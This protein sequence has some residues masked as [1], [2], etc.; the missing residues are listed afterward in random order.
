MA[1]MRIGDVFYVTKEFYLA[2]GR[3]WSILVTP[4][5]TVSRGEFIPADSNVSH[6]SLRWVVMA[7]RSGSQI[8]GISYDSPDETPNWNEKLYVNVI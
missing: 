2:S 7:T 1:N 3:F 8:V 4:G 5:L 6:D